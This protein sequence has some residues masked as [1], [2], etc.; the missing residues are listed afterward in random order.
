MSMQLKFDSLA[1]SDRVEKDLTLK[2]QMKEYFSSSE[3]IVQQHQ[4]TVF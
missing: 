4:A 2:P 3:L 1:S